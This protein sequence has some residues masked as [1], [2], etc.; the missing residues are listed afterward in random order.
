MPGKKRAQRYY[1]LC[2]FLLRVIVWRTQIALQPLDIKTTPVR[3]TTIVVLLHPTSPPNGSVHNNGG[4]TFAPSWRHELIMWI[5]W[6]VAGSSSS[7]RL[8]FTTA[9]INRYRTVFI[10]VCFS[11]LPHLP[12]VTDLKG[13]GGESHVGKLEGYY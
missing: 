7:P 1:N 5:M 12:F 3:A 11:A 9:K 2:L 10:C 4:E 13:G 6:T 8:I